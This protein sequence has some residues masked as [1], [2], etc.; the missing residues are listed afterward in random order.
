MPKNKVKMEKIREIIRLH[1]ECKKSLREIALLTG[2]SKTTAGEYLSDFKRTDL[3]HT[4]IVTMNDTMFGE[5]LEKHNKATNKKYEK[6]SQN[7]EYNEKELKRPGVTLYLLW[8]EYKQEHPDGF[9]YS[10][11]CFHYKSWQNRQHPSMHMEYKAGEKI[12]VDFA[13]K[14][15]SIIDK[16]TGEIKEV[17]VFVAILASSQLTYVE[18]SYSQQKENWISLNENALLYYGGVPQAIVPDNLKSGVTKA[19]KYEPVINE[20]YNDFARHYDTV[21][22]PTRP[23]SPK[24]KAFVENAVNIVYQRIYA[25]LRNIV[26]FSINELNEAIWEKLE[27]HNNTNFQKRKISRIELFREIEEKELK[28]LPV[29]KYELKQF[30]EVKVQFNYHVYFN[31]DKH[32]Y[33]V[34]F[35]YAGKKV[36][37]TYTWSG[38]EIYKN[39][40]RIAVYKRNR[41]QYGYTTLKEHMP[42]KHKF[43]DGWN[44]DRFLK[45]AVRTGKQ[46]EEFIKALLENKPHPE[47]SFKACMGILRLCNKYDK[48]IMNT[49]CKKALDMNIISYRFID[50]CLKNKT[51]NMDDNSQQNMNLPLHKNIRGKNNYQ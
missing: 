18:A 41:K 15:L 50:N 23:A 45:Q 4:S 38:I 24:D 16:L 6:L 49:V 20:T 39:H 34:P 22:L 37:I 43:V 36:K 2:V 47:Q 27:I 3:T 9:S 29:E 17:E 25:P 11:F 21:I 19:C 42:A 46:V 44:S 5:V 28:L 1:Y 35:Q 10:R 13:G 32:Y 48:K 7:F 40:E 12:F 51:Y 30:M 14:K 8:E 33:S 26:F 31:E